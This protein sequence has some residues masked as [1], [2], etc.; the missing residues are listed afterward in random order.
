MT[1]LSKSEEYYEKPLGTIPLHSKKLMTDI[2]KII[3][4]NAE[5]QNN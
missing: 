1:H 2:A 3:M 5:L 4:V